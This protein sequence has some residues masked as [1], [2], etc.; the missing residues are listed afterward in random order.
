VLSGLFGQVV[1]SDELPAGSAAFFR[2]IQRQF[3]QLQVLLGGETAAPGTLTGKTGSPTPQGGANGD[4]AN[5]QV[6]VNAVDSTFHVIPGVSDAIT[7]G[8]S[9]ADPNDIEPNNTSLVN[10]TTTQ[11]WIVTTTGSFTISV[12]DSSNP[13]ITSGTSS[14]VAINP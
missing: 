10:G 3:S 7:F 5:V 13:A 11:T 8:P 14:A 4:G 6:T 2:L 9:T 1:S 12:S